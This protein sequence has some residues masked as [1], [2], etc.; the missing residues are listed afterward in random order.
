MSLIID[1]RDPLKVSTDLFHIWGIFDYLVDKYEYKM[2]NINNLSDVDKMDICKFFELKYGINLKTIIIFSHLK[3]LNFDFV[4][5]ADSFVKIVW[6]GDD[7]H[8]CVNNSNLLKIDKYI[9]SYG[10]LLNMYYPEIKGNIYY[11]PHSYYFDIN[12]NDKPINLVLV[13]GRKSKKYYPKRNIGINLAGKSCNNF[14]NYLFPTFGYTIDK[15]SKNIDIYKYGLRYIEEL[16]KYLVCFA[17][18]CCKETPYI[19]AKVF[20]ILSSGALL[21]Y[22][23]EDRNKKY[24]DKLGFIDGEHYISCP[25]DKIKEYMKKCLLFKERDEIDRVRRNG[26]NFVREYHNYKNRAEV[27]NMIVNGKDNLCEY[28]DGINGTRYYLGI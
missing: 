9:L 2:E 16:N 26:Y 14:V 4:L 24:F 5:R 17:C 1:I 27:I 7:L 10:Y 20:E 8:K 21:L 6:Y 28:D 22:A 13:S 18:D 23:I 3:R 12:F 15:N 19:L 25:K 11:L